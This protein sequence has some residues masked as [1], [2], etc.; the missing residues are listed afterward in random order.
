M[1]VNLMLV[2]LITFDDVDLYEQTCEARHMHDRHSDCFD[3]QVHCPEDDSTARGLFHAF[4]FIDL[5][6]SFSYMMHQ[7]CTT[8]VEGSKHVC[9]KDL[10]LSCLTV[11]EVQINEIFLQI[12]RLTFG[13]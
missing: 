1:A 6:F 9:I 10:C 2:F 5:F 4:H 8:H 7:K 13:G 12:K 11:F 3:D